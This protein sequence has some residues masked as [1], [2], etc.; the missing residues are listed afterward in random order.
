VLRTSWVLAEVDA[1]DVVRRTLAGAADGAAAGTRSRL[2]FRLEP[3][4]RPGTTEILLRQADE[5]VPLAVEWPQASS[6]PAV[7][8]TLLTEI[9]AYL[10]ADV[11]GPAVSYLAQRIGAEGKSRLRHDSSGRPELLLRL[12]F[13]RAWATVGQALSRAELEVTDLDRDAGVFYLQV[14][15]ADLE[16][17]TPGMFGRWFGDGRQAVELTVREAAEGFVL[18]TG[19][20]TP[21]ALAERLLV[22]VQE[23]A[24]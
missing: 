16:D 17:G 24:G 14:S 20:A 10:A 13:D 3:G 2:Y 5:S 9:G 4:I 7:E 19:E 6:V 12:D 22:V 21:P 15:E 23:N 8:S 1:A 18:A 11:G